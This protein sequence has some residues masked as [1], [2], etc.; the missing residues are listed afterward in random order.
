MVAVDLAAGTHPDAGGRGAAGRVTPWEPRR[1]AEAAS[2]AQ[3]Q[4]HAIS[5]VSPA[6]PAVA[7]RSAIA[8]TN[9]PSLQVQHNQGLTPATMYA[10]QTRASPIPSTLVSLPPEDAALSDAERA[11]TPRPSLRPTVISARRA[12]TIE[13]V[14]PWEVQGGEAVPWESQIVDAGLDNV[15]QEQDEDEDEYGVPRPMEFGRTA[16]TGTTSSTG[17]I[18]TSAS[19]GYSSSVRSRASSTN[20]GPVEEVTP[21]E[22]TATRE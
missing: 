18:K 9:T 11:A 21:W 4:P 19:S 22:V 7:P 12:K 14:T 1:G 8:T 16:S 5:R 3:G 10:S 2:Q 6:A 20:A 13:E 15:K 17:T